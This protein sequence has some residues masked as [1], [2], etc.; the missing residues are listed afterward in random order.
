MLGGALVTHAELFHHAARSRIFG[1]GDGDDALK[2]RA[3]EAEAQPRCG[4]FG[5]VPLTPMWL[6][7]AVANFRFACLFQRLQA[8]PAQHFAVCLAQEHRHAVATLRLTREI[9][10]E[11]LCDGF[12]RLHAPAADVARD[13]IV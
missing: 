10:T 7:E 8:A 4:H 13:I 11:T 5:R 3:L 9:K 1:Y 12:G 6:V 2:A